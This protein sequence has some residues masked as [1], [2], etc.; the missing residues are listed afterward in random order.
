MNKINH[1]WIKYATP[2]NLKM[3]YLLTA[4]I[5]LA[6]AAAAPGASGGLGGR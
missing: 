2:Q 4:L 1:L 6:V 3:A 5:A